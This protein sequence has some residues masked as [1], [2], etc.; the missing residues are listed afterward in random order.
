MGHRLHE[1][2]EAFLIACDRRINDMYII[3]GICNSL[4]IRKFY[5]Q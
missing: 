2:L 5:S 4:I 3:K 1:I